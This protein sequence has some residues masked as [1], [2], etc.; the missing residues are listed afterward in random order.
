MKIVNTSEK[1]FEFTFD[2]CN[3]G[4]I[5][6]GGVV[7]LPEDVAN[8][9]LRRS[10]IIDPLDGAPM[11]YRLEPL[12]ALNKDRRQGLA[13]YVCPLVAINECHAPSMS[14][15]DELMSHMQRH[16]SPAGKNMGNVEL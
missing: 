9:A 12:D 13:I 1:P 16:Q 6:P 2:S 11:G 3:Y 4:P 7:D 14:T 8:H 15:V 10:L 5:P